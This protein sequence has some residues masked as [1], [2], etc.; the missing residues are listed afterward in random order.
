MLGHPFVCFQGNIFCCGDAWLYNLVFWVVDL[1]KGS[2]K[3][4]GMDTHDKMW[5]L[6]SSFFLME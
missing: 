4:S 1:G 2:C 3:G 5:A 6:I